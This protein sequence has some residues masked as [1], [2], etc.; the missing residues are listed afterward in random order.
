MEE[1]SAVCPPSLY[2][3]KNH[4]CIFCDFRSVHKW[5]VRR[6]AKR[7]HK[8]ANNESGIVVDNEKLPIE[9]ANDKLPPSVQKDSNREQ[10]IGDNE[11]LVE[12]DILPQPQQ[13]KSDRQ[14]KEK[15]REGLILSNE[16]T[17][18]QTIEEQEGPFDL[19]LIEDFKIFVFGPSRQV[20]IFFIKIDIF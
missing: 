16:G 8:T 9:E 6:H 14:L 7:K 18:K 11:D 3:L 10:A 20:K 17:I 12:K 13:E 5:V 2:K 15:K 19:R 4:K 1:S